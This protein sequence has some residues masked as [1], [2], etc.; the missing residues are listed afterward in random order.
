MTSFR[1]AMALNKAIT[2]DLSDARTI[3]ARFLGLLLMV[4]KVA[5]TQ[6]NRLIITRVSNHMRRLFQLNGAEYLLSSDGG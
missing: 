1:E 4:R 5:A 3:D 6:G 2:I